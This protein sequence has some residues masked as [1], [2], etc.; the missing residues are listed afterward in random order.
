V[1]RF[2]VV[3]GLVFLIA[4][5]TSASYIAS[6]VVDGMSTVELAPGDAFTLDVMLQSDAADRHNSS[7]IRI[8]FSQPGFVYSG[9]AWQAPY[10]TDG[11]FDLSR[12][13]L[14]NL[15]TAID[16]MTLDG[17]GLPE[18][19]VDVELSNLIAGDWYLEGTIAS[20]TLAMPFEAKVDSTALIWVDSASFADGFDSVDVQLGSP[21]E[22]SVVPEP[23]VVVLVVVPL[24]FLLVVRRF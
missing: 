11:L 16:E 5:V 10:V 24:V 15:P 3:I 20:L 17:P 12:P 7:V 14:E 18:D 8:A 19:I 6:V 23:T 22:I 2:C 9:Y 13:G 21:L 1:P 4:E